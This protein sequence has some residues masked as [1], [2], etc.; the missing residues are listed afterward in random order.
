[1]PIGE[2]IDPRQRRVARCV[3]LAA[4]LFQFE[5]GFVQVSLPDMQRELASSAGDIGQ[6]MTLYLLGAVATLLPAGALGR[7][8]GHAR[9]F[10]AGC[11]LLVAATLLCGMAGSL[12][13]LLVFRTLQGAAIALMVSA[14]YTLLPMW[15]EE[16]NLGWGFG[17]V[18]LGAAAGMIIGLPAGG[19]VAH[20]LDWPWVF[21]AQIPFMLAL[22]L[23]A[24]RV[25]PA[26]VQH[27]AAQPR[28]RD[29]LAALAGSSVF[30]YCL[31]ALLAF[32][33]LA[34]GVRYL[35]PFYLESVLG[36][37]SARSGLFMLAFALGLALA[38]FVAGRASDRLGS[39]GFM[40]SAYLTAAAG[41]LV[42]AIA[43]R[44]EFAAVMLLLLALGVAMGLFSS[45]NNRLMMTTVPP[46]LERT[47]GSL[48]P[49]ALNA[50]AMLGVFVFDR[51][52]HALAPAL[53]EGG[54]G[55]LDLFAAYPIVHALAGASFLALAGLHVMATR[56]RQLG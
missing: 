36:L 38:S 33:M 11:T 54:S 55:V 52:S 51:A 26:D 14:G 25:L 34:G 23:F 45:P 6:V 31:F 44:D 47:A 40:L 29:T 39:G 37:T 48:L 10:V 30:V 12:P 49:V 24:L 35:A 8:F 2:P 42:F 13:V 32:Q 28:W 50:G 16:R 1:M 22:L 41:C 3:G 5:A 9:T 18:S 21:L 4:F 56:A 27:E 53:G 7:R 15:L 43:P 17:M 46:A 19:M 20:A